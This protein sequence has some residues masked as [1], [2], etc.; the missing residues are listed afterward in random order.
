MNS[1]LAHVAF[2]SGIVEGLRFATRAEAFFVTQKNSFEDKPPQHAPAHDFNIARPPG[3]Y[4]MQYQIYAQ[5]CTARN[6]TVSGKLLSF[7]AHTNVII[8][9]AKYTHVAT[10]R[11]P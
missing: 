3:M 9:D 11:V 6:T 2:A 1:T 8:N 7:T 4:D 5:Y 10:K